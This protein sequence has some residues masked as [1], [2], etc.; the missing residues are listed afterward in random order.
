M[1]RYSSN[2][3][4][5]FEPQEQGLSITSEDRFFADL[6]GESVTL[7][8][9][10][11]R[12]HEVIETAPS[13]T[14]PITV[15]AGFRMGVWIDVGGRALVSHGAAHA[16]LL[17]ALG[18]SEACIMINRV[19]ARRFGFSAVSEAT[20][21]G[22]ASRLAG[23]GTRVTLT[24]WLRPDKGFI[25][26]MV[27]SLP[28]LA[29]AIGAHAIEFDVEGTWRRGRVRGFANHTDAARYVYRTLRPVSSGLEIAVTCEVD[30]MPT[31]NMRAIVQG[32]D[33]IVPQAY[34]AYRA[35]RSHRIGAPYGP[36]GI[37]DRAVQK[38]AEAVAASGK[39][40]IMGLA[41]YSRNRWPGSSANAILRM[42]L[43]HTLTLRSSAALRGARYWSWKHIAG[44]DARGGRPANRYSLAFF[45][46]T[47]SSPSA[48]AAWTPAPAA[49]PV[50]PA[51]AAK[52]VAPPVS[53][54]APR[55]GLSERV[56]RQ[57]R[58]RRFQGDR[59]LQD[60]LNGR[61]QLRHGS[62]G[63][64]VRKVQQALIALGYPLPRFGADGQFGSET[65]TAVRSFQEAQR[66]QVDGIIGPVTMG[67]LDDASAARPRPKIPPAPGP[68]PGR[69]RVL[70]TVRVELPLTRERIEA[71]KLYDPSRDTTSLR[72]V[73]ARGASVDL[74]SKI[75]AET[76]AWIRRHR[77]VHPVLARAVQRLRGDGR[78]PILAWIF[79]EHELARKDAGQERPLL[80]A[81]RETSALP[82]RRRADPAADRYTEALRA[83]LRPV[84]DRARRQ[85]QQVGVQ[86]SADMGTVPVLVA[87]ATREQVASLSRLPEVT[88]LYLHEPEGFDDLGTSIA[89]ARAATAHAAG[90]KGA[91]VRAAIWER[92][93]AS[94]SD[95]TIED[96]F[97]NTNTAG[98]SN[99]AQLVT[100][101][102]KN[103]QSSGSKGFAPDS[104][105]YSANSYGNDALAWAVVSQRCTV[106][107]Q[108]FHR[109]SE[110]TDP[111]L[112]ADDLIKDYLIVHPP[113]PTVVQAAGNGPATEYVNHKGFNSITVGNHRD[114]ATAM[115]SQSVF[116][117]PSS[118][119]NDR[120]LPDLSANGTTVAATGQ[121]KSGTSFASPAVAGTV[122]VV[123]SVDATLK[124]WPE[125]CRAI[126]LASAGRNIVGGTWRQAATSS[127]TDGID[128]SGALDTGEAARITRVRS[129]RD[130]AAVRRGWDVGMLRTR[131]LRANGTSNFRYR[132]QVP[133]S[134]ARRLKAA[135]AWS[136]KIKYT[137]D[138]SLTPPVKVTE[139]K[140]TV[141]LDLYVYLGGA[142]VAHSS[143]FDNSFEIVEFDAQ[144]GSTYEIRIKRFSGT[145]WA[146]Y[147]L[148]WTVV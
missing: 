148:A 16:A 88:G 145:D 12:D 56:E 110:E 92:A 147:G 140:L 127:T 26:D 64:P 138:A 75:Q 58:A 109:S 52:P 59:V 14:T 83:S 51:P 85:F 48:A 35:R 114:G 90:F 68:G 132:V 60:V 79:H 27:R 131:D 15:P 33:V 47:V 82:P 118:A 72:A 21:R 34:S 4:E 97:D 93:P 70:Q 45:R 10:E 9:L 81:S 113:F 74:E 30:P 123:Q 1:S 139:S 50:A 77:Q 126:L 46:S 105:T 144:A 86:V 101:I 91:N 89:D 24:S 102:I 57:L 40:T 78:V 11:A 39:P 41:A 71:A 55:K 137:A 17:H 133:A 106:V 62:R 42:E 37:Q 104:K 108:S 121:T 141:D 69:E 36:R 107:N 32:A 134:G 44:L 94:T 143:T 20:I 25:D 120:E 13:A 130:A 67:R 2:A 29:T 38:L 112:S 5:L 146:W 100:A 18:F 61:R 7:D 124:A 31:A 53:P 23:S 49:T 65:R 43:E 117:N 6:T 73:D 63:E 125:G 136:S 99:H 28:P 54:P 98:T 122:A 103:T 129:R 66:I 80:V 128:G 115:S 22:F 95:L 8:E 142:L 76:R 119:H 116:K 96:R 135:L 3:Y 19:D 84:L 87:Q 111:G